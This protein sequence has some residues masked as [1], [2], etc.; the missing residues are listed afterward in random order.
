MNINIYFYKDIV[1]PDRPT[2]KLPYYNF[3]LLLNGL[4][5]RHDSNERLLK[6]VQKGLQAI[7]EN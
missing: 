3:Y 2:D 7:F 4:R 1:A 6:V 5:Y